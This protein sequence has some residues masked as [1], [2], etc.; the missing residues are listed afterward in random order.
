MPFYEAEVSYVLI[1]NKV[2]RIPN[3]LEGSCSADAV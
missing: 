3:K 2:M 1:N